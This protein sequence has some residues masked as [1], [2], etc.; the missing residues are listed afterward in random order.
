[1][2]QK[3]KTPTEDKIVTQ[4]TAAHQ[5]DVATALMRG[6]TMYGTRWETDSTKIMLGMMLYEGVIITMI[7]YVSKEGPKLDT[8]GF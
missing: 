2:L 1:M 5:V 4:N 6:F 8:S 7:E 3:Y